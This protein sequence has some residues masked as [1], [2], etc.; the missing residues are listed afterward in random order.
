MSN[1]DVFLTLR[2]TNKFCKKMLGKI[3]YR[4]VLITESSRSG[5]W[6]RTEMEEGTVVCK[7][8]GNRVKWSAK[9]INHFEPEMVQEQL[10]KTGG[11]SCRMD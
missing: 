6:I 3:D 10:T 7:K 2:C 1:K 8:C 4:G 11:I 9:N 5:S